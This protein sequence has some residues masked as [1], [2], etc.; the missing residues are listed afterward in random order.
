MSEASDE[1]TKQVAEILGYDYYVAADAAK[2]IVKL[3]KAREAQAELK[4]RID[5]CER[6]LIG[7]LDY[8]D[9]VERV[10]K[11]LAELKAMK[12]DKK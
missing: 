11:R 10:S 6:L 5:E 1:L 12:G 8:D 3:I 2:D 7:S 4:G 9:F